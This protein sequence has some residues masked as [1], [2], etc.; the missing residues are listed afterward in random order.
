[1]LPPPR[2]PIRDDVFREE[3]ADD[4]PRLLPP[5]E[6]YLLA[7]RGDH[8]GSSDDGALFP[9]LPRRRPPCPRRPERVEGAALEPPRAVSI[10]QMRADD[11]T[12]LGS[13]ILGDGVVVVV[14]ALRERQL[15]G[16]MDGVQF[17]GGRGK[18]ERERE[19]GSER[20]REGGWEGI[21]ICV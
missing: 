13:Y 1:M 9:P 3:D 2:D 14:V 20:K 5:L 16:W 4:A 11:G 6:L 12:A 7:V 8:S 17:F 21:G 10:C 19:R 18:R 15:R